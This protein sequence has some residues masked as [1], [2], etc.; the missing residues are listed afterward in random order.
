MRRSVLV[1]AAVAAAAF[2]VAA[3]LFVI[4]H[5]WIVEDLMEELHEGNDSPWAL[6]RSE[7]AAESP[8]WEKVLGPSIAFVEM[9]EALEGAKHA[10]IRASAE[11]YASAARHLADAVERRDSG[12]LRDS[13]RGLERSCG[14][15]HFDGGVGGTLARD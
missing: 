4:R 14:D 15:C 5:D 13:V 2:M 11:G 10:D 6:V 8:D 3:G 12:T 1:I 9:A 7:A